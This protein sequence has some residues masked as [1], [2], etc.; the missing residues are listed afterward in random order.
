LRNHPSNYTI[1]GALSPSLWGGDAGDDFDSVSSLG[2]NGH[3]VAWEGVSTARLGLESKLELWL[4]ADAPTTCSSRGGGGAATCG[5]ALPGWL[6]WAAGATESARG[7]ATGWVQAAGAWAGAVPLLGVF[8]FLN[9]LSQVVCILGVQ[10]LVANA[11]A[12]VISLVLTGRKVLTM[13][14]SVALFGHE[15]PPLQAAAAVVTFVGI[16]AYSQLPRAKVAA[17][18]VVVS[19]SSSL[20]SSS[21]LE[22]SSTPS[23]VSKVCLEDTVGDRGR[24]RGG[25]SDDGDMPSELVAFDFD[26]RRE[27]LEAMRVTDLKQMCDEC[28]VSRTGLTRKAQFVDALM[29]AEDEEIPDEDEDEDED[30]DEGLAR[31]AASP[32][33]GP[34]GRSAGREAKASAST[35]RRRS[36]RRLAS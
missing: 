20:S 36:S 3:M 26:A 7:S 17:A 23:P 2:A 27:E 33:P 34:K 14:L 22:P 1:S 21:S 31:R 18:V 4:G 24:D 28:G 9:G 25:D 29:E 10:T 6:Q 13:V 35:T 15:M 5:D 16:F 19:P 32:G 8:V 12:M 11:D 30:A